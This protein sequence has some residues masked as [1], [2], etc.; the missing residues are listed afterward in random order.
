MK[1]L[2]K[3]LLTH[4]GRIVVLSPHLD[5]AIFSIGG[6]LS[7]CDPRSSRFVINIFT[8]SSKPLTLSAAQ[9]LKQCRYTSITTLYEDR[10]REDAHALK[11]IGCTQVNLNQEDALFRKIQQRSILKQLLG[12]ILPEF[13]HV[14]PT[15]KFHIS[16]GK[17]SQLDSITYQK[18]SQEIDSLKLSGNDILL[19]PLGIGGHVDHVLVREVARQFID[20]TR[21]YFY[22]DYPYTLH[23]HGIVDQLL[24]YIPDWDKK[25]HLMKMYTSQYSAVFKDGLRKIP[26][27]ITDK[28]ISV[29]V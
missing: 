28:F 20:R 13:L 6:L 15:Y 19:S 14:Y 26:E 22:A 25:E 12:R 23:T 1:S 21:V 16:K 27:Y 17:I 24:A 3:T 10:I 29:Y 8:K 11:Q 18:I 4:T 2:I 7:S 5:D 9:F